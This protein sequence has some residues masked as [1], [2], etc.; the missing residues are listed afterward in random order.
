MDEFQDLD[1]KKLGNMLGI[2]EDLTI[3]FR[4]QEFSTIV[5]KVKL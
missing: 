4:T 2:L 5:D 1:S 3:S